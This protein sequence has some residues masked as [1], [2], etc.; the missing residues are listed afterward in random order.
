DVVRKMTSFAQKNLI[1]NNQRV[2][3][4]LLENTTVSINHETGEVSPT[5]RYVDFKNR[6]NNS[7]I[8]ISQFKVSV[9][10]TEHHIIPDVV[11]FLNGLPIGVIECKSPKVKEPIPEAIDQ[12][13][14][15]SQQRGDVPEGNA[16]LFYYNQFL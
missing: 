15:Y 12:M 9:L 5:V 7:F 6:A 3:Q 4:Y 13:L 11:L 1:E 16:E 10:G 2:L 8:A 14:R